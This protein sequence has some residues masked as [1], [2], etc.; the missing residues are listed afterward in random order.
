[1]TH[2]LPS[3]TR[4]AQITDL[5]GSQEE[6]HLQSEDRNLCHM[7]VYCNVQI[8]TSIFHTTTN[9]TCSTL[10]K[11]HLKVTPKPNKQDWCTEVQLVHI[12]CKFSCHLV[13]QKQDNFEP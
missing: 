10:E 7:D 12:M 1:M 4:T 3:D 6:C 2:R 13:C 11:L 9:D 5:F 8:R